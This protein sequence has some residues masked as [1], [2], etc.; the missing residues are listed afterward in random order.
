MLKHMTHSI[1]YIYTIEKHVYII[2]VHNFTT[3]E[4]EYL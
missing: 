2:E 1:L 3:V 4:G